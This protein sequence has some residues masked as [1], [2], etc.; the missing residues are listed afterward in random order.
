M[1]NYFYTAKSAD[2]EI[3]TGNINAEDPYQIA[4]AL[5]SRGMFLIK[6]TLG[7]ER[8]ITAPKFKKFTFSN[9]FSR[10]SLVEKIIMTRN[11]GVMISTGL[12]L[13]KIFDIL[14]KQS[15]N[16]KL[17]SVFFDIGKNVSKGES[18]S[19]ALG[20]YPNIF[21]EFFVNMVKVGEESGTLDEVFSI[22]SLHFNR[23]NEL[24]SKIKNAMI[25]P[26]L[27]F[28]VMFCVMIVMV[29]FVIPNLN[30][31][32]SSFTAELPIYTRILL[33]SGSFLS[34]RWYLLIIL[35]LFLVVFIS[36]ML[37][38]KLT[39]NLIETILLKSPIIS[40]I[41]KKKN[42]A[43]LIRSLSSLTSAGISINR[44]LEIC[45]RIVTNHHFVDAIIE[46]EERIKKG[47]K[48]S[49]ALKIYENIFPFGVIEMVEVGEETGKTA[50][51]LKKLAEFYEQEVINSVEKLT[52]L[53][54]P[55][56]IIVIGLGVAF[57]AIA[58]IEPMYST[59]QV[60]D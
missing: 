3:E 13:V 35:P 8:E 9:P 23:T 29:T 11:M 20:A 39:R 17:K 50:D 14:S 51:I 45:S 42:S 6:F 47:E 22:L 34:D 41:I 26:V 16:K 31:F 57:F 32:F 15:K 7:R 54:E 36:L 48:L 24:M 55:A 44:S 49:N 28:I 21:S 43:V 30:L 40:P 56:L 59:L 46:A 33:S 38:I 53:I 37:R 27:I 18:F 12:P 58:I 25:Y 5:R 10:V 4:Q 52:N 60:I 1:P 2:G 19:D